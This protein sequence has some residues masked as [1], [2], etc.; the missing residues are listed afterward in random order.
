MQHPHEPGEAFVD[1]LESSIGGEIRRRNDASAVGGP[2]HWLPFKSL[3]A[4]AALVLVSMAVGGGVV[5]VAYE[6]QDNQQRDLIAARYERRLE[7][8]REKLSLLKATLNDAEMRVSIGTAPP[9]SVWE[10]ELKVREGEAD[11]RKT[12]LHILE[13]RASG[14]EP[15]DTVSAPTVAGQ[16]F[17][18][19]RWEADLDMRMA[20]LEFEKR[21]LDLMR[22]RVEIGLATAE[23]RQVA[24]A[25]VADLE[26]AVRLLQQKIVVR[27]EFLRGMISA[28]GADLR[29]LRDEAEHRLAVAQR[30]LQQAKLDLAR[31][32]SRFQKGLVQ[33][34]DVMQATLR[35]REVETELAQSELELT[36]VLKR[37]SEIGK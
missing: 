12:E 23:E 37:L 15:L 11:V 10:A 1:R 29:V 24:E 33:R 9:E 8:A 4:A 3:A 13:I 14:R 32:E 21:R 26:G 19:R 25:R 34:L 20:M 2:R 18:S 28:T 22:R 6:R 7:L 17:V 16:D 30:A 36:L 35:V 5:A 31:I 27:R